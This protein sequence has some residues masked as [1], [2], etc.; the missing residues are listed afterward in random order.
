MRPVQ[1]F[2][3]RPDTMLETPLIYSLI[4]PATPPKETGRGCTSQN[5]GL[6]NLKMV[7]LAT[8][9]TIVPLANVE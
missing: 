6:Q 3:A 5:F 7:A 8:K 4:F 2:T 9:L 1:Q